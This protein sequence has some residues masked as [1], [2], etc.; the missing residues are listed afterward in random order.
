MFFIKGM[1]NLM[2]PEDCISSTFSHL[3][4][5]SQTER[6]YDC[7]FKY[8]EQPLRRKEKAIEDKA[9]CWHENKCVSTN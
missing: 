3:F 9:Y 4:S 5:K 8:I 6:G 7:F 1:K 2:R